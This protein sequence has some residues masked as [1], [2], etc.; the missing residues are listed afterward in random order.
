MIRSRGCGDVG[1]NDSKRDH[2]EDVL[3]EGIVVGEFVEYATLL[4][5]G[6]RELLRH[7]EMA[8]LRLRDADVCR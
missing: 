4:L 6:L 3:K 1:R 2:N 8:K 5:L 7:N